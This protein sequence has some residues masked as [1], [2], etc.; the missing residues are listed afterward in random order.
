MARLAGIGPSLAELAS[1]QPIFCRPEAFS[2]LR[3]AKIGFDPQYLNASENGAPGRDRTCYTLVRSQVLYPCELQ[4]RA[5][6][7]IPA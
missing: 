7:F 5:N 3:S 2:S 4:A 6:N 1:D